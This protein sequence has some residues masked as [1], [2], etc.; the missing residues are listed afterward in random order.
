MVYRPHDGFGPQLDLRPDGSFAPPPRRGL[1]WT[2]RV[3][4]AAGLVALV[5]AGIA[6]A[7]LALWLVLMLLPV[8]AVAMLIAW[9]A[10]RIQ[11]WRA[12]RERKL[13]TRR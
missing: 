6:G 12:G 10:F 11:L 1:P 7:A 4:I 13:T 2:M 5:A 3:G 9:A 8:I